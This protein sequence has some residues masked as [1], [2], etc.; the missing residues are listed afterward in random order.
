MAPHDPRMDDA[1]S[2]NI[3]VAELWAEER[4]RRFQHVLDELPRM[5]DAPSP[6]GRKDDA[7]KTRYDLLPAD[8]LHEVAEIF[9]FGARKYGDR[10]WE[11]GLKQSRLFGAAMRHLWAYWRGQ[12]DDDE[13]GRSHLAHAACCVLMMLSQVRRM[14]PP[15]DDLPLDLDDRPP[16]N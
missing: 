16:T 2:N 3:D 1:Q 8:A 5:S 14:A 4:R 6:I 10:N 9:T 12:D 7:G 11:G 15:L 13:T